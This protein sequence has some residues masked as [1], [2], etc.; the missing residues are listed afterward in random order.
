MVR[1]LQNI[2]GKI[3]FYAIYNRLQELE[4]CV[5]SYSEYFEV[6]LLSCYHFQLF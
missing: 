3:Y 6:T 4:N 5:F 2:L 1:T